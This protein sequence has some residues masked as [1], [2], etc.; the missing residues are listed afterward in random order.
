MMQLAVREGPV[1][2]AGFLLKAQ[3]TGNV[4]L[5]RSDV[6]WE[7]PGGV[8]GWDEAPEQGARRELWEE[9][10]YGGARLRQRPVVL[11]SIFVVTQTPQG[12]FVASRWEGGA[13]SLVYYAHVAHVPDEFV[14]RLSREHS[15]W[16]WFAPSQ[17]LDN[18]ED[19]PMH[20]GVSA[21]AAYHF[22]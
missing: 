15:D 1:I 8:V 18:R 2:A 14:P 10:G 7:F 6:G 19:V 5:L 3:R 22:R 21:A 13:A 20:P 17:V 16:G 4:L 9:T 12:D 11:E